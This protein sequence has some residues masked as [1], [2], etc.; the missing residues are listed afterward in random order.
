MFLTC[1]A[2]GPVP[3]V[4]DSVSVVDNVKFLGLVLDNNLNWKAHVR[5][6]TPKLNSACY[7]IKKLCSISKPE[8]LQLVYNSYFQSHLRYFWGGGETHLRVIKSSK[9]KSEH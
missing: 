5:E 4:D 8:T 2:V 9:F 7:A 6:L 3:T 1:K